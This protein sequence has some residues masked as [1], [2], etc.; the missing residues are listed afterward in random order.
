MITLPDA[1][2]DVLT[3]S[4]FPPLS[5]LDGCGLDESEYARYKAHYIGRTVPIPTPS[6]LA[7]IEAQGWDRGWRDFQALQHLINWA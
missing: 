3:K 6:D 1:Q 4:D 7:D 5:Q 2:V